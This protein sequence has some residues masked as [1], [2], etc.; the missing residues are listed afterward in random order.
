MSNP[1]AVEAINDL[2]NTH[3]TQADEVQFLGIDRGEKHLLSYS[4]I[5]K[6]GKIL[7][8]GNF[9]VINKKD[10]LKEINDAAKL[11]REKQENWQQKGNIS[12]LKYGYISLVVHEIIEKMKDKDGKYRP[13]F[14]V[15]EDLSAGFK[16]SRQKF[17]QQIYQNFEL[18]LA[19]KL[20]YLVDKKAENDEIGSISKALQLTPPVSNYKDI[21][22]K[23][24]S[25]HTI[26][27]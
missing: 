14:I 12:N 5:N 4:L 3:F 20:N 22:N 11:R 15:L 9:D 24:T 25:R 7:E 26:L 8:Q 27:Y 16:R 13:T 23:K 2:V 6:E 18:A 1:K 21:E 17:E 10:Y 19:K